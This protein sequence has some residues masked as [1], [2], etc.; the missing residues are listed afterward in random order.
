MSDIIDLAIEFRDDLAVWVAKRT[1]DHVIH[2]SSVKQISHVTKNAYSL[3]ALYHIC[4]LA[5]TGDTIRCNQT[6]LVDGANTFIERWE[7]NGYLTSTRKPV[8]NQETWRL[9]Y[10]IK[11]IKRLRF[12]YAVA[13][14]D[15]IG[16]S[17][18]ANDE[19]TRYKS[20]LGK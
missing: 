15:M 3:A 7:K 17:S 16:V 8:A 14:Y 19:L 5:N 18:M 12:E 6:Y 20:R 13:H 11:T 9:I 4:G 1:N 2:R 10:P